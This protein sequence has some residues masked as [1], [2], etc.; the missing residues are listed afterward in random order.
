MK[1]MRRSRRKVV[2]VSLG[3]GM[4]ATRSVLTGIL[5]CSLRHP[6][7][8]IR[9]K[10][11]LP[12]REWIDP[13]GA[14]AVVGAIV[15]SPEDP[16]TRRILAVP[17]LRAVVF[18]CGEIPDALKDR[19]VS[20]KADERATGS[21]A[22]DLFVKHGLRQFA[23]V[24]APKD[25]SWDVERERSFRTALVAGGFEV[26]TYRHCRNKSLDEVKL[27]KWLKELPSPCGVFVAYDQL[28][29]SVIDICRRE[30]IDVPKRLQVLGVDNEEFICELSTP[31]ISSVAVDFE[32]G[33]AVALDVLNGLLEGRER[34]GRDLK[35]PVLSVV[36]RLSTSDFTDSANR[37]AVA[38]EYI[39]THA[40]DG[41]GVLNVVSR[42]TGSCR[43][44]EKDFRSVLG[45]TIRDEILEVRLSAV[46]RLLRNSSVPID[47]IAG[48]CGFSRGNYLKNLFRRRYG[49]TMRDYRNGK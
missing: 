42:V 44:L 41:I 32:T 22:A 29:R 48:R 24:S 34:P 7:L 3:T 21:A 31:T 27:A 4:K 23:Y 19:A 15:G 25:Y 28:A 6:D 33:G 16:Q 12:D 36:E 9:M 43:M 20:I 46:R 37:V 39:R 2:L 10:G 14:D 49:M 5:R 40:T 35:I 30:S 26:S 1:Q 8:E 47:Q 13:V 45:R 17:N 18:T 11:S 38:R